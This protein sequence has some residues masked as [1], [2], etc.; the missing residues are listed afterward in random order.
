MDETHFTR[1]GVHVHLGEHTANVLHEKGFSFLV[2]HNQFRVD[3]NAGIL[4]RQ[5]FMDLTA[6]AVEAH[7]ALVKGHQPRD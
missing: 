6:A 7:D 3:G 1:A 2:N 5:E 4:T